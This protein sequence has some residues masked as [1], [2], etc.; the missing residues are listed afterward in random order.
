MAG[1]LCRSHAGAER[2]RSLHQQRLRS[3]DRGR[4]LSPPSETQPVQAD[5]GRNTMTKR[6]PRRDGW[7]GVAKSCPR[8]K[9]R[10]ATGRAHAFAW[11]LEPPDAKFFEEN[12][13]SVPRDEKQA[14]KKEREREL[15]GTDA[16][17]GNP[18]TTRIPTAA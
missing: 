12:A 7:K 13:E 17:D 2:H 3:G 10:G 5:P 9:C 8:K 4:V 1:H 6:S 14:G 18:H 15:V 11:L 16:A